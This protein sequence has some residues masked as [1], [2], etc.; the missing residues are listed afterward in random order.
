ML[1]VAWTVRKV[2]CC[3]AQCCYEITNILIVIDADKT[4]MPADVRVLLFDYVDVA[5][6]T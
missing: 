6:I 1:S 4:A 2:I 5:D 3:F